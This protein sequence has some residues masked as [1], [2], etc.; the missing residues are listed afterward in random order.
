MLDQA[1]RNG[2]DKEFHIK[3][4]KGFELVIGIWDI[5]LF[6]SVTFLALMMRYAL[7]NVVADDYTIFF[8]PWVATLREAGGGLKGL[9]AE[10]EYVDYTTP[11]LF[12]L[13]CISI[14]PYLNTLLLMK[15]VSVFF[16][17][18][19]AVAIMFIVYHCKKNTT[20]SIAAYG[21]LLL[22]PTVM[23]NSSMWAQ[24]DIIFTSFVL[25]SV[26]F[27]LKEK[28]V[29][30]MI[31]YGAA[32]AFKLQ[33]LFILPL[34]VILWMKGRVK[35]KHFL[36]VPLMYLVGIIPGLLA[37]QNFFDLIGV[38]FM[39][40]GGQM[41]IYALSH[42]F[43]NIYQLV[44]TDTFLIEYADA[45]IWLALGA[46]MVLM[47]AFA[48]KRYELTDGLILQM[49]ML[50]TMT[51]VFFLPHMHERY[52]VLVDVLAIAYAFFRPRKFYIPVCMILSSFAGYSIYLAKQTI[53]PMYLYTLVFVFIMFDLGAGIF[54][55]MNQ[56]LQKEV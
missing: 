9:N 7:R 53:V 50:F 20:L 40:A 12:I 19:A 31:F 29:P 25:W 44:G 42:K 48:R 43:P 21:C 1:I 27:I 17:F 11:Y 6:V 39:Q 56:V 33:T 5:L 34:F 24:C 30:A 35:L 2:F 23:A 26:Y 38:Y 55:E 36:F 4:K 46:L 16:D 22:A 10:F 18:V 37:G 45:G 15:I 14:C 47:Y 13:S 28:P 51:V 3:T 49:G 8:E 41:D 32:F 54:K 52:A